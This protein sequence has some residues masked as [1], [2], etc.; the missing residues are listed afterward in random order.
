VILETHNFAD[1]ATAIEEHLIEKIE[2]MTDEE[3]NIIL[4]GT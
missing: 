4:N 1:L 3:T 2:A